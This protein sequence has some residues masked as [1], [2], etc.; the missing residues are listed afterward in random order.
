[1]DE[2]RYLQ[3]HGV[4]TNAHIGIPLNIA[5][6]GAAWSDR[7]DDKKRTR[8]RTVTTVGIIAGL[9]VI[10]A[11][12]YVAITKTSPAIPSSVEAVFNKQKADEAKAET[13][14][15][16]E[17]AEGEREKRT[18]AETRAAKLEQEN[19][20]LKEKEAANND[21]LKKVGDFMQKE[22]IDWG[23]DALRREAEGLFNEDNTTPDPPVEDTVPIE[24]LDNGPE[25]KPNNACLLYTSDA[26]DE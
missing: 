7:D 14:A 18:E 25:S 2:I 21:K 17:I 6:S 8:A 16:K 5:G 10:A 11:L 13:E 20:A 9:V 24:G 15:H 3:S 26:A 22:G 1:M 4:V 23:K 12:A 19:K